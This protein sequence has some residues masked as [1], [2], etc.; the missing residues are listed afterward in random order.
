MTNWCVTD[1]RKMAKAFIL[2][3]NRI[4]TREVKILRDALLA[5]GKIT[6]VELDFLKELRNEAG[7]YV[8]EFMQLYIDAVKD[9]VLHDG[10]IGHRETEWLRQ[11]I[12]SHGK[13]DEDDQRLLHELNLSAEQ[14][15]PEFKQLYIEVCKKE[16]YKLD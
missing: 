2:A 6:Q 15:T 7:S 8:R 9:H 12:V 11:S 3:D 13:I 5:D 1:W 4:D 14:V 16:R 10:A